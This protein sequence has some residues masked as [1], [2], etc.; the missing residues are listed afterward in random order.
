[1]GFN[2]RIFNIEMLKALYKD[3]GIDAVEKSFNKIDCCIFEDNKSSNIYQYI[4]T[5]N[6]NKAIKLLKDE[7]SR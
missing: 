3:G 1:M 5:N 2:K 7:Q 6:N 4:I